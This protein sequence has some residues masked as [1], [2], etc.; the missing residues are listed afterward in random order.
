MDD[1]HVFTPVEE[2]S[3]PPPRERAG[4]RVV[5]LVLMGL[6]FLLGVVWTAA[7]FLAGD[8]VPRGTTVAGVRIGG[9]TP[10]EA[11]TTLRRGLADRADSPFAVAAADRSISVTPDRLGLSVDYE[12]SVAAAGGGR[13]WSPVRLWAYWTGGDD[14]DAVV[15]TDAEARDQELAALAGRVEVAPVDGAIRFSR[16]R[17]LVSEPV[18]GERL[19]VEAAASQF[20]AAYLGPDVTLELPLVPEAPDIDADDV[21]EA[22]AGF[23][24]PAMARPVVLRFRSE[25]VLLRPREYSRA[26]S[27][28]ARDGELVPALD[29]RALRRLVAS[30]VTSRDEPV[31]AQV[32]LVDGRPQVIPASPG[33]GYDPQRV[34]DR[35]LDL[36]V[37]PAGERVIRVPATVVRPD[38]TTAEARRLGIKEQVSTFTTYFPYA[39]Y[40]NVNIGRA[41]D[42]VN[43]TVLKPGETFSLN[44][45][46]GERTVAN[47]FT[48]GFIISDGIFRE[49]LGGG[50]S[51]MAT[52]TFNA[53]FFAGLKDI[54]HK[55]HSFYISRYPEGREATV[56]W[57]SIDLR[58]QNDTRYGVLVEASVSPSTPSSQG[59]VTVSMWST[60]TWDIT[61]T[62]S[63][64]S[65]FTSPATR[66]LTTDDCVPNQGY[67]GFDV[68]VYRYFR[69]PGSS[70]LVRTERFDTT[71]TPSDTVI[72][73]DPS[74]NGPN[75]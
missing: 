53:A 75:D 34:T 39:E 23:G 47:G 63:G 8:R 26:I 9:Q 73:E 46:V 44:H 28:R 69:R 74:A 4:G 21:A 60:K 7:Y 65:A 22:M 51:Q 38:L 35:F 71:Y 18:V 6:V 68:S 66:T 16:G 25:R 11:E 64:R 13:S 59:A 29:A 70:D 58:F 1:A 40:R 3:P 31:D 43:G 15:V 36:V 48:E 2:S 50:V 61:T 37:R 33:V 5:L 56:S 57:G 17:A 32:R 27:M 10:G 24:R 55:P 14:L 41:A 19:D 62:T 42:L 67:G 45:V 52:T 54:E 20:D 72:C 30:R 12:A 49:D